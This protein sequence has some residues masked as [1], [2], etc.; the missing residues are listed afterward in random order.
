MTVTDPHPSS[1]ALAGT[2]VTE[3]TAAFADGRLTSAEATD[4]L[5]DRITQIDDP[6]S[7]IALR[8]VLAVAEDAL[9]IA[10]E[11]DTERRDGRNRGPLHGVPVLVKDNIEALG[12]PGSAGSLALAARPPARD[13][14]L[15]TRLRDAGAVVLGATN[16]SEWA[17]FRSPHSS[18]GWSAV[19]G[20]TGNPWALDRSAGGSS[21]GSG[22]AV[23]AG[24]APLA[25]GTETNGSITCPAALNGVVGLKP[26]VGSVSTSGVVPISASQ[27][28]PGPLART[29]RDAAIGY[30]VLS[31]RGDCLDACRPDAAATLAVG[32][33]EAWLTGDSRTDALFADAVA[34]LTA[35]VRSVAGVSVPPNDWQVSTDQVAVLV[36]ELLDDMDAYLSHRAGEGSRSLADIVAFNAQHAETEL[37]HFGQEYFEDAIAGGGRAAEAYREARARNLDFAR[38]ACLGPAFASGV[39]VLVAPAYRPAWKSDLTLG[40]Q[41]SG[42]GAVCT[43]AAIVGWPILTVPMGAVDGLPVGL[44]IVG[45]AGSE[46]RL[47]AAG[48]ALEQA[49]GLVAAGALRPAW[50][51]P[52]RG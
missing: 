16:L 49:L 2:T 32:V 3:M 17:N 27:D 52:V 14:E 35:G 45:R 6:T 7:D 51:A 40:D 44:S 21:S 10:H 22:A 48:H 9:R 34:V 43:P 26:T 8:S 18:S 50:R 13:A 5:L 39:D 33:V 46:A 25:V 24:L 23:A 42:G 1:A 37:G 41:V 19:G 38:N 11:R 29:V 47:I 30:E 28:V 15:V 20:L 4:A 12:L 31:G 36:G